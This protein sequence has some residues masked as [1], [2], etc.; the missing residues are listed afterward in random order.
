MTAVKGKRGGKPFKKGEPHVG[1]KAGV[2]NKLSRQLKD[3]I[4]FGM[5]HSIHSKDG[6]VESYMTT[7][8]DKRMDLMVPL[9]GKLLPLLINARTAITNKIVYQSVEEVKL[10]LI[11]KGMPAEKVD[12]LLP[13]KAPTPVPVLDDQEQYRRDRDASLSR[14]PTE[15]IR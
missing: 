4:I 13:T 1:R 10:A 5:E 7:V 15:P 3:A 12:L 2:P 9:A 6:T 11:A 14:T 8:A